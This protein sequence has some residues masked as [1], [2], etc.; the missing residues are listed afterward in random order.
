MRMNESY[1]GSGNG[2]YNDW[3]TSSDFLLLNS[4]LPLHFRIPMP[5]SRYTYQSIN[6]SHVYFRQLVTLNS[7]EKIE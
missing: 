5:P 3:Q 7:T 6:Q 1:A 2:A 4:P